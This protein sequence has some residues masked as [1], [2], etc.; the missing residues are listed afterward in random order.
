MQKLQSEIRQCT[1]PFNAVAWIEKKYRQPPATAGLSRHNYEA[2]D[3]CPSNIPQNIAP[4]PG[5][6]LPPLGFGG[7]A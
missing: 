3:I 6:A 1:L 7:A 2:F 5:G 4:E